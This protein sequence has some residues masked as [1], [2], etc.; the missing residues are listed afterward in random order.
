MPVSPPMPPWLQFSLDDKHIQEIAGPRSNPAILKMARDI[1]APAWFDN[2]DHPWCAVYANHK[3]WRCQLALSGEG[4]ELLRA[5][6]FATY[7]VAL[8]Q[9][10]LGCLLV[11]KRPEGFHVGFYL[12]ENTTAYRVWGGNQ[13]NQTGPAWILKSRCIA[14]RWPTTVTLPTGG[15]ILLTGAGHVSGNEA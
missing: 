1:E 3:L 5:K 12:G 15:P 13:S 2:D 6:S 4:F 7:G 11:F 9:P 8:T 10:A 14:I